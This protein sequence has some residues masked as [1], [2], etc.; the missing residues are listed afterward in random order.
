MTGIQAPRLVTSHLGIL[1]SCRLLHPQCI[2]RQTL[3]RGTFSS[4]I[5]PPS[6]PVVSFLTYDQ[7]EF[8]FAMGKVILIIGFITF[9]FIAMLGGNPHHDRLGFRYWKNVRLPSAFFPSCSRNTNLVFV[10]IS[11]V[12]WLS[13]TYLGSP[14]VRFYRCIHEIRAISASSLE[15]SVGSSVSGPPSVSPPSPSVVPSS[16]RCARRRQRGPGRPFPRPSG[17]SSGGCLVC[18]SSYRNQRSKDGD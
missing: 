13:S 10:F 15:T 17:E 6:F 16:S 14:F 8:Y 18:P 3:W 7:A 4:P 2:R 11:P 1:L 12:L 5:S 9:T